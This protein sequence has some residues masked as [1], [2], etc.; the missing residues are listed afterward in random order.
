MENQVQQLVEGTELNPIWA[1][2][3]LSS[4]L[5]HFGVDF[6]NSFGRVRNVT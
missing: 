6:W 4:Q 5:G 2:S 3:Y 1:V